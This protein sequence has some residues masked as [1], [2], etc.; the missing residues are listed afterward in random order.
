MGSYMT[1][2]IFAPAAHP[3][4]RAVEVTSKF[5][6]LSAVVNALPISWPSVIP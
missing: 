3:G 4:N 2:D 5:H 6:S 1:W